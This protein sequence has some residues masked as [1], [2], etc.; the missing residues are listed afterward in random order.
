MRIRLIL[1]LLTAVVVLVAGQ[2]W[3]LAE[4]PQPAAAGEAKASADAGAETITAASMT[5]NG[6]RVTLIEVARVTTFFGDT[7]SNQ[8]RGEPF[9]QG[10]RVV[11]M[12]EPVKDFGDALLTNGLAAATRDG[13]RYPTDPAYTAG[14]SSSVD[15]Y[16]AYKHR[17]AGQTPDTDLAEDARIITDFTHGVR[18]GD[19]RVNLKISVGFGEA[20]TFVFENVP[21]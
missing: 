2:E 3:G 5:R 4:P 11:Y 1:V 7:V 20:Q 8:R 12:V 17:H 19:D 18:I 13:E 9:T 15:S 14:G 6:V 10:L 21:L 16:K